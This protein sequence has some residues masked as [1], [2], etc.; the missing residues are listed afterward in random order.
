MR[1]RARASARAS[2]SGR[3][4]D[5][6]TRDARAGATRAVTGRRIDTGRERANARASA[7]ASAD[8]DDDDD[9]A[10][11][12]GDGDGS[13]DVDARDSGEASPSARARSKP[14]ARDGGGARDARAKPSTDDLDLAYGMLDA[15]SRGFF[16]ARDI[17][18]VADAHGFSDWSDERVRAMATAFKPERERR[19]LEMDS[20]SGIRMTRDEFERAV[21]LSNARVAR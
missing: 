17:R 15:K 16:T 7:D 6:S 14:R 13:D 12:D 20:G 3:D 9:D 5:A 18:R 1:E 19:A 21:A 8:D 4:V 2:A 11:D 10:R